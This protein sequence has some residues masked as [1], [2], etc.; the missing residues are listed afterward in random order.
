MKK[1]QII[2]LFLT[3]IFA[4]SA[5]KSTTSKVDMLVGKII[6]KQLLAEFEAFDKN[7]QTFNVSNNDKLK[8][9]I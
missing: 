8:I 7:Y 1:T 4:L 6:V 3:L 9:L 2:T 5:C